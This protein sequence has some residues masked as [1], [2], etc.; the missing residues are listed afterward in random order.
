M[1]K[2]LTLKFKIKV[3]FVAGSLIYFHQ[4]ESVEFMYDSPGQTSFSTYI[5]KRSK[6]RKI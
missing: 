3:N 6:R 2:M 5:G 1:K 4:I